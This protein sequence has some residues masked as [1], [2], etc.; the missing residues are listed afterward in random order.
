M[1]PIGAAA[2]TFVLAP[3]AWRGRLAALLA[4]LAGAVIPMLVI[5]RAAVSLAVPAMAALV[6]AITV[7]PRDAS[8]WRAQAM[9]PAGATIVILVAAWLA[10]AALSIAPGH[11]FAV[12]AQSAGLL[13]LLFGL[14]AALG[15]QPEDAP[16][17]LALRTLVAI[18]ALG[19]A[20]AV[21]ALLIWPGI[22]GFRFGRAIEPERVR[23]ALKAYGAVQPCLAPLLIW[24][25]IKFGGAWR[26]LALV[27]L[28]MGVAIVI[29][30]HNRSALGGYAGLLALAGLAWL[31]LRLGR[32][33]RGVAI[34]ALGLLALAGAIW[35]SSRLPP[36]PY[37]GEHTLAVP[38]RV[39]DAHRQVIW[40]FTIDR[41]IER[42][43]FG[44]GLSALNRA[45]GANDRIPGIGF[46]H[47][48]LHSHN[49]PLQLL[50]E[51]GA[52]GLAA[53]LAALA[54]WL[55]LLLRHAALGAAAAW[56]GIGLTG[57]FFASGLA[58]FS[59]W[60]ARWQ[61]VFIVLAAL[62]LAGLYRARVRN[63]RAGSAG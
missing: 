26:G 20:V 52:V 8:A 49:W 59:I 47:V 46:E 2:A 51:S 50:A 5:G 38:A 41:A 48:P 30:T 45:P 25:A 4:I 54:A 19:G 22:M 15:A 43:V 3:P 55:G 28:P 35:A 16:L 61:A 21:V 53:A 18:A 11:S 40:S 7:W 62:T 29:E 56:A 27:A 31:L 17:D 24:A 36:L 23:A 1:T 44:W 34:G 9:Q 6:L 32:P 57:A 12:L 63:S 39:I 58:N 14:A 37:Q 42:P 33:W 10:S 60:A 13:A